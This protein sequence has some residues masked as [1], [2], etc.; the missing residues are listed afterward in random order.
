MR[1]LLAGDYPA[2]A[3]LGSTKV[4]LKL[5]EEFRRLGHT[6][7]VLLADQLRALP[8]HRTGR[9]L[10]GPVAAFG[11]IHRADRR[12][13]GYDVID[14]ASAEGLWIGRLR[15][16]GVSRATALV[17]RSNGLEHLNYRRMLDDAA[18]GLLRKPATRRWFYPVARLSQVAAA[19]RAADRLI[20]L[21]DRDKE[22]AVARRWKTAAA[23][24][25]VPHG[26]SSRFLAS[27]PAP[28]A[29]RGGG[30]L[31]C[32]SW[33][34]MKGVAYLV[35]AFSALVRAGAALQPGDRPVALTVLGGG[36]PAA[37]IRAQFPS[38]VQPFVTVLD[39]ADEDVVVSAY[40][41]HDVLVLPSTYEGFGM[42]VIEAMSQ[43]LPVVATPVGCVPTVMRDGETGFVV[44][45]RDSRALAGAIASL[46][47][48]PALRCRLASAA[49]ERVRGMTW[50]A[51]AH[52]TLGVYQRA[53]DA[54]RTE[55]HG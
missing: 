8:R 20:V 51:T 36:W 16:F 41:R 54:R 24:D 15:P 49:F 19:A 35:D 22:F 37:E 50:T 14:A 47:G 1:I 45:P 17:A 2:D 13:G 21:N 7:D 28:D 5:Q 6:C 34:S 44:P 33:D 10:L 42:V 31:F 27:A 23:V 11:A 3:R 39:R 40:R 30:V 48:N 26:V 55:L 32:A 53:V 18:A 25:V 29:C 12:A 43:R 46:L 4:L 38:D 52:A 9:W